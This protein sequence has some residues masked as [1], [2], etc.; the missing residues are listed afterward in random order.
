M[1]TLYLIGGAMGVGK[2]TVC[3][4]LN[5][6]LPKSVY[7]DGDWCWNM[8][9]FVVT[10]ETKAMVLSNAQY[11]LNSFICCSEL[12]NIIFSW[13]MDREEIISDLLSGLSLA[14]ARVVKISLVADKSALADRI[15]RDIAAGKRDESALEKGL[16]RL[17]LYD[18]V[19]AIKIDTTNKTI[20]QICDEIVAI[21]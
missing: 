6:T 16:A 8:D 1:K 7:L 5:K 17:P 10:E 9:P 4:E 14:S 2:S 3:G 20:S 13:V 18:D 12:D 11:L 15:S 19:S 21:K